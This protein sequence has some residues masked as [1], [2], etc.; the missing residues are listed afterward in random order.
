MFESERISMVADSGEKKLEAARGKLSQLIASCADDNDMV[1]DIMDTL[2]KGN[3]YEEA[4]RAFSVYVE[5]REDSDEKAQLQANLSA[6]EGFFD[7]E[8]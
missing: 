6:L 2:G 7:V 3:N 1:Q 4:F 5:R 8:E